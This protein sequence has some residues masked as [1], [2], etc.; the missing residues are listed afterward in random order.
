VEILLVERPRGV[1]R[2]AARTIWLE[3]LGLAHEERHSYAPAPWGLLGRLLP[4]DEVTSDDVFIDLGSGMGRLLLEAA[5]RYP[6]KRVVGV[7]LVP[8]F[9]DAAESL[10]RRN[11][12]R[13]RAS[14]WE[15]VT[16]DVADY[17]VPDDVTIVYLYNP[18]VGE[19]FGAVLAELR[20][21]FERRPRRIRILYITPDELERLAHVPGLVVTKRATTFMITMGARYRYVVA[22]LRGEP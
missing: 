19:L 20:R 4:R 9:T 21:S 10:L 7:E 12:G 22:E 3:D 18:V 2:E 1:P 8:H 14:A 16:A 5:E 17:R 13:M 11:A 15:V 6:F